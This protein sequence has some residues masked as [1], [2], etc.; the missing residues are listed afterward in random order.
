[1]EVPGSSISSDLRVASL[2]YL[3]VD[4]DALSTASQLGGVTAPKIL[5]EPVINY[6]YEAENTGNVHYVVSNVGQ[7]S[8][9]ELRNGDKTQYTLMPGTTRTVRESIAMPLLPGIYTLTYGFTD[10]Q[11]KPRTKTTTVVYIPLWSVAFMAVSLLVIVA[12]YR[13]VKRRRQHSVSKA[14]NERH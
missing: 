7:V 5:L 1:M 12:S 4:G 13:A 11:E 2:L 9:F 6:R 14:S 8:G 10:A 3:T